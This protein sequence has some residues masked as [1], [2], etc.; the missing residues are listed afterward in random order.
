MSKAGLGDSLIVESINATPGTFSIGADDLITL[1][2]SGVSERVIRAMVAK[3]STTN[4]VSEPKPLGPAGSK[5]D[6]P[7]GSNSGGPAMPAVPA[8]LSGLDELGIYYKDH[9]G[10]WI[11]MD[12]EIVNFRSGGAL[13]SYAT[14][15]VIKE[16]SNG[17]IMGESAQLSLTRGT[18]FLLYMPVGT[19]PVEYL[20]LLRLRPGAQ[21]QP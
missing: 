17:H 16:D 7:A 11:K 5:A 4:T 3:A 13:K 21:Q 18:T 1:K 6:G 15:H 19:D 12:P 14:D 8:D 20:L 2:K 10:K 9:D